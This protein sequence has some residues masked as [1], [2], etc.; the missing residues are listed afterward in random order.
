MYPLSRNLIS[1]SCLADDGFDYYFG[2]E[3]CL[4][5]SNDKCVGLVFQ[6]DKLYMLSMHENA[7]VYAMKKRMSLPQL[8]MYK[9]SANDAITKHQ[10]NYGIIV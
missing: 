8:R 3:Q 6:Q 5:K 10:Q 2:K 1:V 4:V 7:N 9:P